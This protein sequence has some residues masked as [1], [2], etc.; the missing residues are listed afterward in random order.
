MTTLK[1]QSLRYSWPGRS[2]PTLDIGSFELSAG[3]SAFLRGPSGSGKSTLLAAISGTIDITP[4]SVTVAGTDVGTLTGG[5][6]DKF[7]VDHIGLIFQVFNLIPY[8]SAYD[9]ILLPC[10]FS[11]RRREL[12]GPDQAATARRLLVDMGLASSSIAESPASKLSVGQQQRVAAARALIGKPELI[13]ADEPSSALDEDA[14]GA[15]ID[16]LLRECSITGSSLLFVSHDRSLE[17][18]FDRV[19]DF[20]SLNRKAGAA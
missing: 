13:L 4:G 5:A 12:A 9:N 14:K 17:Q 2:E 11:K 15:F 8:L 10:Q 18:H 19:I 7:R 6:R 20:G 3:E 1:L 16:L